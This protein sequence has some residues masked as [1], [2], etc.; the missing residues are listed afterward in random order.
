LVYLFPIITKDA[1]SR[2]PNMKATLKMLPW[3]ENID[4]GENNSMEK[5]E[6]ASKHGNFEGKII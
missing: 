4:N 5:M 3:G 6:F 1:G 2:F